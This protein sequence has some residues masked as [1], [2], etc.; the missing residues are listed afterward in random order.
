[1][2]K[3]VRHYVDQVQE[4]FPFLSKA[5]INRI[6]TFGLKRYTWV[7]RMH[8]DVLFKNMTD[9]P[10][11]AHCG[12]LGPDTFKHYLRWVTKWRMKE[13]ILYK[14]KRTPWDGY[15]YIGVNA[16]QHKELL[17]G[18]KIKHFRNIYL[19]KIKK[20]LYHNKLVEHIWRVPWIE[21]CGWKFFVEKLD[22]DKAEYIGENQYEKYHEC[23]L[24]RNNDGSASSD[25]S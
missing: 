7:N 14:L 13:R 1:M 19:T 15:Y 5:E 17:K 18:R 11:V 16:E 4:K 21:D 20:E 8:G 12:Y 2:V 25:N 10:M 6:I 3:E 22:S 24:K 9:E 23:F